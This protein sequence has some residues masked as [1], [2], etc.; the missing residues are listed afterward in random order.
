MKSDDFRS[1]LLDGAGFGVYK[2]EYG[3]SIAE[4]DKLNVRQKATFSGWS[5]NVLPLLLAMLDLH[6]Q[7]HIYIVLFQLVLMVLLSLTQQRS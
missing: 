5:I 4:V 2:D 7:A 1:G 6:L 3:K